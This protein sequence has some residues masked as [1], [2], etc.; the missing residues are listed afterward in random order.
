VLSIPVY[1]QIEGITLYRDDLDRAH[2]QYLS[3]A[4]R[5]V[6]GPDGK[7]EF[8]FYR[9]QNPIDRGGPELGGGYL[10]FTTS[11][12]EDQQLLDAKVKPK[13]QAAVNAEDPTNPNPP[14]VT[15]APVQFTGGQIQLIFMKSNQ[16]VK[17]VNLGRPSLGADNTASVAVELTEDGAQLFYEALRHG[18]GVAA[19]E[20]DL[21]Y[22]VRLPAIEIKGHIDSHEVKTA[23]MT[24]TAEQVTDES[25]W[26]DT[27]HTEHH[28]TS[29]S[30]TMD[31]QGLVKLEI[32]KG[33]VDLKQ[34]DEDALRNYAFSVMDDFVKKHFMPGGDIDTPEDRK[35]AWMQFIHDDVSNN[36]DLDVTMRD[37]VTYPYNPSAQIGSAF[38]GVAPESVVV[39][40][41][42]QDA[43]WYHNLA[44]Q[45]STSLDWARFGDVIHSVVGTF[46]Y[47]QMRGDGSR[48][49]AT[50]SLVFTADDNKSKSFEAHVA[51]VG[52]DSY[53]VDVEVNYKQGP[54]LQT[55]FPALT[56]NKRAFTIDI[57]N[58]GLIDIDF[59]VD[60][61]VFG[62]KLSSIEV[63]IQ[64]GDPARHVGDATETIVLN[65]AQSIKT[66]RRWLYAPFDKPLQWRTTYVIKDAAGNEQRS[67]GDWIAQ[68]AAPKL[69]ITVHSP[70]EDT[71]HLRVIPSVDW[72]TV[73]SVVVD[74]EYDNRSGDLHQQTTLSFTKDA[75]VPF[76]DWSFPLRQASDR[77][78]AYRQTLLFTNAGH[79]TSDWVTVSDNPGTLVVGNAPGGV[80]QLEVDPADTGIE[81]TVKRVIARLQ[82]S[83]P[84]HQLVRSATLVFHDTTPQTW[85]IARA[86]AAVTGYRY[87]L[88]YVM[89]DNSHRKLTD[90]QG[91]LPAGGLSDYLALPAPPPASAPAGPGT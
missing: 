65:A 71:F 14:Q 91:E 2:F 59:A 40:I 69:Y 85:A 55:T 29:V 88:E 12:A 24:M 49:T 78:F 30:E 90:Q 57:P 50:D 68:E 28:R 64:Y 47:D 20:Y 67:T 42:L 63:E 36:F 32:L 34:E 13:L 44:V 72:T 74:L 89:N 22:P 75:K 26:G 81:T 18:A 66:Y 21:I 87:N 60:P 56:T 31:N 58:P 54:T 80:V 73:T 39:D 86:D 77:T 7:P 1:D 82:Y 84:A 27:H 17:S 6:V 51:K 52:L 46:R 48:S 16:F 53:T 8:T 33:S 19:I 4:P 43:P 3:R 61:G 76:Q 23:V 45:V 9:Y 83:D 41:D 10:L 70:F 15:L 25:T 79:D 37:V 11:L 62:D 38:L 35:S 5:V